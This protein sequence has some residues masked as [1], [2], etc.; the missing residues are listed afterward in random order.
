MNDLDFWFATG[1]SLLDR[2]RV[3][4][5]RLLRDGRLE[6]WGHRAR[7]HHR[8]DGDELYVVVKGSVEVEGDSTVRLKPGDLFGLTNVE[9]EPRFRA[10]DETTIVAMERPDFESLTEDNGLILS[11]RM[12]DR[13]RLVEVKIELPFDVLIGRNPTGRLARSL[14]EVGRSLDDQGAD[15]VSLPNLKPRHYSTLSALDRGTA[16][17]AF[18]RLMDQKLIESPTGRLVIPSIEALLEESDNLP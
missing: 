8:G 12:R 15:R 17:R 18:D 16:R 14:A 1:V 11:T 13:L 4:S 10:F 5:D 3:D 7:I 2:D 6:R 9:A